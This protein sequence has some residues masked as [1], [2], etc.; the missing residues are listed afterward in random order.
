MGMEIRVQVLNEHRTIILPRL[1][2]D[3]L[4]RELERVPG[5]RRKDAAERVEHEAD[6]Y[7]VRAAD[8]AASDG[9]WARGTPID[10]FQR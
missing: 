10:C 6:V 3:E 9:G 5:E 8:R 2:V 7:V 4:V 1:A